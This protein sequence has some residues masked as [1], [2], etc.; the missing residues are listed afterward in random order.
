MKK[1]EVTNLWINDT[2]K[3]RGYV[4]LRISFDNDRHHAVKI[5]EPYDAASLIQSL[6]IMVHQ[7]ETDDNLVS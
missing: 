7:L 1:P 4:E 3:H 2:F 5:E 6:I